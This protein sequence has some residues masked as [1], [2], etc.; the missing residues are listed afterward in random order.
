MIN[1][2][3]CDVYLDQNKYVENT[4]SEF[5]RTKV[6]SEIKNKNKNKTLK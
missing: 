4:V 3:V 5:Q 2:Y 1:K 6:V